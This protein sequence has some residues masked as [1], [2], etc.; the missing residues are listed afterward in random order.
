MSAKTKYARK[1]PKEAWLESIEPPD[2][3]DSLPARAVGGASELWSLP[4][5]QLTLIHQVCAKL[6]LQ[7]AD[8]HK[9]RWGVMPLTPSRCVVGEVTQPAHPNSA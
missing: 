6:L 3:R 7:P 1:P 4:A 5:T 2:T 8:E 9:R